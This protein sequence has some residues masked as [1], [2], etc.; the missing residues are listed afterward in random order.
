MWSSSGARCLAAGRQAM[1]YFVYS[2]GVIAVRQIGPAPTPANASQRQ[3]T[4]CTGVQVVV[5]HDLAEGDFV[6]Q[7][8]IDFFPAPPIVNVGHEGSSCQA[9]RT[10]VR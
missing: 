3:P 1:L 2:P 4:A 10:R 8:M 9:P 7:V 6:L 5:A